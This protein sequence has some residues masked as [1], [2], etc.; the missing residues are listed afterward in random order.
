MNRQPS[1]KQLK[2]DL[3]KLLSNGSYVFRDG[4]RIVR[5]QN[6]ITCKVGIWTAF[7]SSGKIITE[8]DGRPIERESA[9]FALVELWAIGQG[10]YSKTD[11]LLEN[12]ADNLKKLQLVALGR[13]TRETIA[14]AALSGL[15]SCDGY[16]RFGSG[17]CAAMAIESAD[18]L[19][20]ELTKESK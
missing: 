7:S 6:P 9:E 10:P 15:L 5:V 12:I 13:A 18:R 1:I 2:K 11:S 4:S 17:N 3:G 14:T 8:A 20:A 19:L 16:E